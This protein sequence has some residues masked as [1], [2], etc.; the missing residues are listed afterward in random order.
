MGI[1]VRFAYHT[2][3]THCPWPRTAL[4][5]SWDAAG[6]WNEAWSSL[7]MT[8]ARGSDDC[9]SFV[10]DV[11]FDA[12]DVG[13]VFKWGV[14][15]LDASGAPGPWAIVT[16]ESRQESTDR[17]RSFTLGTPVSPAAPRSSRRTT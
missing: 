7:E 4:E 6:R 8:A 17:T 2:G 14:R 5:G 13:R 10:V 3:L 16:E 1:V 11:T 9:P 12:A 15:F